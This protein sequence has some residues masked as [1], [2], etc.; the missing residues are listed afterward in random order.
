MT[1]KQRYEQDL[2][3]SDFQQ[4]EAQAMAVNALDD[5]YHQL[6]DYL[7]TPVVKPSRWQKLLGKK[8]EKPELPKGLYFWGE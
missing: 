8:E 6:I 3:R 7:N 5:L 1:P 4:D 2:K